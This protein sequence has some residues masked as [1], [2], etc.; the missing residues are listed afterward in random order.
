MPSLPS[1]P[2]PRRHQ[3]LASLLL[4]GC[5]LPAAPALAGPDGGRLT[6]EQAAKIFPESR[7]LMLK[8][9]RARIAILEKGE[10][11]VQAA[12]D[13]D[14]LRRCLKDERSASMRQRRQ[15]MDEMRRLYEHNGLTM[16]QW[17]GG[18]SGEAGGEGGAN[19]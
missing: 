14:A 19:P 5:S 18:R 13:G 6:P 9:R 12:G 4:L 11:C 2:L 7:A 1:L 15:T 10:R 16:P 3:L 8:D 17:R